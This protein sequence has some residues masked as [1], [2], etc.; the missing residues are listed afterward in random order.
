[1][2]ERLTYERLLQLLQVDRSHEA[3]KLCQPVVGLCR[4]QRFPEAIQQANSAILLARTNYSVIGAALLYLSYA[5]WSLGKEHTFKLALRD[6]DRA[7]RLLSLHRPNRAIANIFRAK[8]ELE[9]EA[10][11]LDHQS[12]DDW[13]GRPQALAYLQRADS[14]LIEQIK[15]ER[16]HNRP[17][18]LYSVLEAL[19]C[20]KM[21][22]V[23]D[24]LRCDIVWDDHAMADCD[25]STGERLALPADLVWPAPNQPLKIETRPAVVEGVEVNQI[26]VDSIPH[27]VEVQTPTTLQPGSIR[28]RPHYQ[29]WPLL[30]NQHHRLALIRRQVRPDSIRQLVAFYDNATGK[31]WVDWAQSNEPYSKIHIIGL[32]RE[33]RIN[34]SANS[35]PTILGDPYMLGV[36]EA[37]LIP[38]Q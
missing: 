31:A 8:L 13:R 4:R 23:K 30:E 20:Q 2:T 10:Y 24:S 6:C 12:G 38:E 25:E 14:L 3:M 16:E 29:V 17:I 7:V 32:K 26:F 5:Q 19:V 34:D 22:E 21:E 35:N 11:L 18:R 1:M 33:W 37:F 15:Y 9:S 27:R 36:V 28:W